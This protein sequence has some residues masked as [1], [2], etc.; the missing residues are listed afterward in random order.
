MGQDKLMQE[1]DRIW[2]Y[3]QR[4]DPNSQEYKEGIKYYETL[5]AIVHSESEAC[6]SELDHRQQRKLNEEKMQLAVK[7]E[8]NRMRQAKLDAVLGL[9]KT[10]LTITGTLLAIVL[11]GALEETTILSTKCLNWVKLIAPKV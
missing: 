1:L 2:E 9:A 8:N 7:E 5:W 6:D 4:H 10:G 3:L 11:T